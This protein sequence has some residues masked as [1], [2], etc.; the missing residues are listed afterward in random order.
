[1]LDGLSKLPQLAS[2]RDGTRSRALELLGG[3]APYYSTLPH[4][5]AKAFKLLESTLPSCVVM[6][7]IP[8]TILELQLNCLGIF[9]I[10][11][12]QL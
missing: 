11:C 1:M 5:S 2:G 3:P 8:F 4:S 9:V 7:T 10:D 12:I 6:L